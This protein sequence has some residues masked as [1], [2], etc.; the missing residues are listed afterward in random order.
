[1]KRAVKEKYD[2]GDIVFVNAYNEF[3]ESV[4]E[5]E[6]AKHLNFRKNQL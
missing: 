6:G 5:K 4:E 1:M 2:I 3:L